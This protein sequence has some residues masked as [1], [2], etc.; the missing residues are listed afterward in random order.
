MDTK[1][2]R[3]QEYRS[4]KNGYYHL[5][6]DGWK[7]GQ[8]FQNPEQY[9][10]GVAALALAT[11]K[12]EMKIYAYELMP[13]HM[14]IVLSATGSV[15]VKIFGFLKQRLNLMLH[16]DGC[17]QLPSDY[18]FKLIPIDT[19]EALRRN[20]LYLARNPYE[21]GFCLPG[22]HLWGSS[23]LVFNQFVDFIRGIPVEQM[24]VREVRHLTG[25]RETFPPQWE[26][27]HVLGI[28]PVNFVNIEKVLSLFR[29]PKEYMTRLVKDYESYVSIS[30]AL[31]EEL[32]F[33]QEE[34]QD[35]V[36]STARNMFPDKSYAKLTEQDK[37]LLAGE[38]GNKYHIP[39]NEL[40]RRLRIPERIILQSIKS[41]D[42]GK[43]R[44]FV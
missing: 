29:S 30:N 33:S 19:P 3:H 1:Q 8:I 31:E 6:T 15:C 43:H 38:L 7:E 4:W 20:I 11:L 2:K 34:L 21:K 17:L 27:H 28:L 14:H 5:C 35:I 16:H 37:C 36:F 42:I 25:S 22:A 23:Y 40:I 32:S 39:T 44:S 41:K 13:N 9:R 26:I 18:D 10:V 12:F 24:S